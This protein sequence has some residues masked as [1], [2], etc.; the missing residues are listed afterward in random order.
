MIVAAT[1]EMSR[2]PKSGVPNNYQNP[3]LFF[4]SRRHGF[5]LPADRYTVASVKGLQR[6]G[7][8]FLIVA[9]EKLYR[10]NIE[11]AHYLDEHATQVGPG[12]GAGCAIYRL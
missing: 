11:L 7:A 1:I 5:S 4:Y 10:S 12:I 8:A 2:D 3:V 9:S 6:D